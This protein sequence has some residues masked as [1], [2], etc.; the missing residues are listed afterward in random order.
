[1]DPEAL[2]GM[3][4]GLTLPWQVRRV[5]FSTETARWGIHLDVPCAGRLCLHDLVRG[6]SLEGVSR[7]H[8]ELGVVTDE[9]EVKC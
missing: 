5:E 9:L 7:I 3:V 4:W 1:M 8:N 2:F 6:K